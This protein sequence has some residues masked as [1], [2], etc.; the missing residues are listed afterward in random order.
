MRY[1][2]GGAP[3]KRE[4]LIEDLRF[5]KSWAAAPLRTGAVSPSSRELAQRMVRE[6]DPDQPGVVVELGPGTGVFTRALVARG[7]DPARLV[8]VEA[9]PKFCRMLK[10]AFPQA[11]IIQGDAYRLREHLM[12]LNAGRLAGV[13]TGLPLF[14]QPLAQRVRLIN[15]CLEALAPGNPIVQFSYALVPPVPAGHGDYV[16]ESS[17]WVW[18]NLPPARVWTYRRPRA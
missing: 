15:D 17:R 3:R 7:V 4:Q 14:T 16:V 6:I 8:L 18:R 10:R 12:H 5:L 9:N 2:P 1:E 13:I 11:Q